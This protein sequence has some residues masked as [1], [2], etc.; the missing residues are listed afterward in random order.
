MGDSSH[1]GQEKDKKKGKQEKGD[2]LLFRLS[3]SKK[4][5]VPFFFCGLT[6]CCIVRML[7]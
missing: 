2:I 4:K 6:P 7:R 1:V 3:G 5:N